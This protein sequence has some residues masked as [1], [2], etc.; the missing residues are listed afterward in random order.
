MIQ[1]LQNSCIP[2]L[3][4]ECILS[5]GNRIWSLFLS[6]GGAKIT[7]YK[8]G[9]KPQAVVNAEIVL[10]PHSGCKNEKNS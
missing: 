7:L 9:I 4:V 8:L 6:I 1:M 5:K 2:F 10:K 3:Y